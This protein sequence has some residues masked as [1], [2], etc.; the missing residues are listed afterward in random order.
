MS[1]AARGH[2]GY[3]SSRPLFGGDRAAQHVQNLVLRD[4]AQRHGLRYLLSAVE[5]TMPGCFLILEDVLNELPQLDGVLFYSVFQ[6]PETRDR[7]LAVLNRMLAQGRD[8]HFAL[9]DIALRKPADIAAI[10]DLWLILRFHAGVPEPAGRS[11]VPQFRRIGLNLTDT[12]AETA[13]NAPAAAP[14]DP[15]ATDEAEERCRQA[16]AAFDSGDIEASCALAREALRRN[17]RI[18]MLHW[19]MIC[20]AFQHVGALSE[21]TGLLDAAR[22][23]LPFLNM[24]LERYLPEQAEAALARREKARNRGVPPLAVICLPKSA[25]ATIH[26]WLINGTGASPLRISLQH[27][28]DDRLIESW[29]HDFTSGGALSGPHLPASPENVAIFGALTNRLPITVHVRDPR[30]AAFSQVHHLRK[31]ASTPGESEWYSFARGLPEA[32]RTG[33]TER[34]MDFGVDHVL[35]RYVDWI[36]NWL[37]AAEVLSVRFTTYESFVADRKALIE[38]ILS[39]HGVPAEAWSWKRAL[40]DG[41]STDLHF[42]SGRIDDWR[43]GFTPAQTE[44]ANA[45]VPDSLLDRFGWCR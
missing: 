14:P 27:Y 18:W 24:S 37:R 34:Q 2:R 15:S 36:Q 13:D 45:A 1:E 42:R 35:P 6:L 38:G 43:A 26:Q 9:E 31:Y 28:I 11:G 7:R 30:Q 3:V 8:A 44:R 22:A 29:V 33:D 12:A 25:S 16:Y 20:S 10:E 4:Y 41:G 19:R 23:D 5:Y 32:F 17:P 40:G 39:F 21:L